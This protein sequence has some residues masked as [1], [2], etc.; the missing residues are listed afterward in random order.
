MT[1]HPFRLV[2]KI[3]I[4]T[5]QKSFLKRIYHVS[6]QDTRRFQVGLTNDFAPIWSNYPLLTTKSAGQEM[7][8]K[9]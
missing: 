6:I 8:S 9:L 3:V 4:I 7:A 2:Q 1:G 5:W